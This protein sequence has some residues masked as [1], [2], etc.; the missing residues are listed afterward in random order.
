MPSREQ[1]QAFLDAV[2]AEALASG[3]QA[4]LDL[5]EEFCDRFDLGGDKK[6]EA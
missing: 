4:I 6:V 3:D 5:I 2:A 1:L